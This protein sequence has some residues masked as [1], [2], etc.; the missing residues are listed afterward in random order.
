MSHLRDIQKLRQTRNNQQV[1]FT[2]RL[3]QQN[4][5]DILQMNFERFG[6]Q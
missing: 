6:E 1:V 5:P 3:S 4:P 2:T